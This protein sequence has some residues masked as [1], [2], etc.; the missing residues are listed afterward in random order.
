MYK[1][2]DSLFEVHV[3]TMEM[4]VLVFLKTI[5]VVCSCMIQNFRGTWP[6]NNLLIWC[7]Q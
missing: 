3:E 6:P 7:V 4:H 1:I 2:S 5:H